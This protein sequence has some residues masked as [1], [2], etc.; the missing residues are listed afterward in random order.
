MA[1]QNFVDYYKLLQV[2]YDASPEVIRAAYLKLS[3]SFHPDSSQAETNHMALLN[4]AFSVLNN[5]RSRN[6]YHQK[7]LEHV[8]GNKE[9][10]DTFSKSAV[11]PTDSST[12]AARE[13]LDLFF[14]FLCVREWEAAYQLLTADDKRKVFVEDF[15]AWREAIAQC[16]EI[17]G[18]EIEY[19]RTFHDCR[20][21]GV[22]YKNVIEFTVTITEVNSLTSET[23]TGKVR[24]CCVYDGASWKVWLSN[25]NIKSSTLRFRMEAE[26]SKNL[27]PMALYHNAV[28]RI[29]PL[30]GLLSE[31]GFYIECDK[32]AARTRRY[33]NPLSFVAFSL[34]CPNKEKETAC[35]CQLAGIIRDGKRQTDYAARLHND[36]IICLLTET[37]KYSGDL[38]ARKFLSLITQ[39]KS[40]DF[41]VSCG[42]VFYNGNTDI[43]D[44]VLSAC[45]IADGN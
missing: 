11:A 3:K 15:I 6:E 36:Q 14:R 22:M 25:N 31:E 5:S 38:A 1:D 16:S 12:E 19:M 33:R 17:T 30:T 4:E 27:D 18:Y 39:K 41:E 34:K 9:S 43:R 45:S 42:V 32:E 40:E 37:R 35:L 26:K 21:D 10:A 28:N 29:D 7:W 23:Q 8:T 24:K 13:A 44:A 20:L 2:H